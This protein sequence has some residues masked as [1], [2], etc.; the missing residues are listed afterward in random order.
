MHQG[1]VRPGRGER[2]QRR[3]AFSY[4]PTECSSRRVARRSPLLTKAVE[5]S[6]SVSGA[7]HSTGG[8]CPRRQPGLQELPRA[9][10]LTHT[11]GLAPVPAQPIFS[12]LQPLPAATSACCCHSSMKW[13]TDLYLKGLGVLELVEN[14]QQV[15]EDCLHR[16]RRQQGGLAGKVGA[17]CLAERAVVA[18]HG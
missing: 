2:L 1:D 17:D 5:Q 10:R 4:L 7:S 11:S 12:Y 9:H 6:S 15:L 16:K 13:T 3:A 8:F 18:A 14:A